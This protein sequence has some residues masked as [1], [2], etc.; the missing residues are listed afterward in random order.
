MAK[1]FVAFY[2]GLMNINRLPIF[3][4]TFLDGMR[5]AGNEMLVEMHPY[6]NKDFHGIPEDKRRKIDDF[7]PDVCFIFNNKLS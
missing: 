5:K 1:I 7:N 6:F 2:N 4:E 3:Y